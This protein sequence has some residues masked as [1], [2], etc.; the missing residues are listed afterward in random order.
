MAPGGTKG[1]GEMGSVDMLAALPVFCDSIFEVY[2]E[3]RTRERVKKRSSSIIFFLRFAGKDRVR[4][5]GNNVNRFVFGHLRT[6]I[7]FDVSK[8]VRN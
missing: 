4:Q 1:G 5:G 7:E 3:G 8:Y 2:I 6:K